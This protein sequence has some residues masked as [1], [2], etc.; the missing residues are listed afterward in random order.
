MSQAKRYLA[1][2]YGTKRTGL[3]VGDDLSGSSQAISPLPM[4]QGR[5]D[6]KELQ[7]VVD[8]WQP[9]AFVL[10]LPASPRAHYAANLSTKAGKIQDK[11][12]I[13]NIN[14]RVKNF[15]EFLGRKFSL[16]CYFVDENLS[17]R[18]AEQEMK[19]AGMRSKEIKQNLD[20]V[21]A[22]SLLREWLEHNT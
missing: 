15:A 14:K 10:G 13:P 22:N 6:E 7:K 8:K 16:P 5:A 18:V 20:S 19:Q 3:A 1:L 12:Q 4:K 9:D 17:S 2:D 11:D 21:V